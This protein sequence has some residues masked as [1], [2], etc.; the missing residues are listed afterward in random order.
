MS[1]HR[2]YEWHCAS[3]SE[4]FW[5]RIPPAEC[6]RGDRRAADCPSCG[7]DED[8]VRLDERERDDLDDGRPGVGHPRDEQEERRF[9]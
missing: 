8:V 2:D 6:Y 1:R 5:A 4:T 7:S 3:C 9:R